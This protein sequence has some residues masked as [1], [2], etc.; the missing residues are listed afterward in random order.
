[1]K[2]FLIVALLIFL[3][4][5]CSRIKF[6]YN[7]LDWLIPYYLG[8]YMEL[9]EEQSVYV[10]NSLEE[11][12]IWHCSQQLPKYADL[13]RT[14]NLKF[15]T[16]QT[17]REDLEHYIARFK[18]YW[19]DLVLQV[20]PVLGHILITSNQEQI[21]GLFKNIDEK[22]REWLEEYMEQTAAERKIEY[23]E[24]VGEEL[25]RWFGPLNNGQHLET[26]KWVEQF[27]P[28]GLEGL[29]MRKNWQQKLRGVIYHRKDL[30][31]VTSGLKELLL[32]PEQYRSTSY[33][34]RLDENKKVTID[35]IY[36]VGKQLNHSQRMH[37]AAEIISVATDFDDLACKTKSEPGRLAAKTNK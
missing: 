21:N 15:Q 7:Q 1:M 14:A 27:T 16:G 12:L 10:E 32:R 17:T 36:Q 37:L 13:F 23:R 8:T 26:K 9:T 34:N 6:A 20:T 22:N 28:L 25:E 35:L 19:Q 31:D 4:L 18:E 5:G 2:R 29:A 30:S 3:L 33:Q 24:R 11:I